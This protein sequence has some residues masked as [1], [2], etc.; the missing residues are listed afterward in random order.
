MHENTEQRLIINAIFSQYYND[1]S[2][3]L[4]VLFMVDEKHYRNK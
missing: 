2:K 1:E 3:M 4:L